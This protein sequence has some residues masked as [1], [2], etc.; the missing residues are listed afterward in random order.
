MTTEPRGRFPWIDQ[1]IGWDPPIAFLRFVVALI[2]T[3]GVVCIALLLA[4]V[5]EQRA[6]VV[7]VSTL[8]AMAAAV[9]EL[10][11]R[12]RRSA[13]VWTMAAGAWCHATL[14]SWFGG[15][16]ESTS[17]IIY[18]LIIALVGWL[19]GMRG[20]IVATALSSTATCGMVVAA[21]LGWLPPAWPTPPLVRWIVELG[22]FVLT[23]A[24]VRSIVGSFRRRLDDVQVLSADLHRAQAVAHVGSWT[25]DLAGDVMQLS[26]ETSRIFGLPEGV[27]GTR[28]S[29]LGRVVTEDRA[30][31]AEAWDAAVAA[32][33]AFDHEHRIRV[34]PDV[35]WVRQIAEFER[36]PDG[37]AFRAVGTTQEVTDRRRTEE[38]LA[39][40]RISIERAS[41]ALFWIAPDG[42]LL[43]ANAAACTSL[44][45]TR[46]ELLARTVADVDADLTD[47]RWAAHRERVARGGA[48]TFESHHR[49]RDGRVF[50]VEIVAS[51]VHVGSEVRECAF[52]RDISER[53]AREAEVIEARARLE[54]TFAALPDLLF[55]MDLEGR[56][57][58]CHA[59][60]GDRFAASVADL[61]GRHVSSVMPPA[62]ASACMAAL[63]EAHETGQSH[64][65]QFEL[66]LPGGTR[67]F[68][69]SVARKPTAEGEVPRF[70]VVSRDVTVRHEAEDALRAGE[71]ELRCILASTADG[72][73]AVN[74]HGRVIRANE[75]FAE[76]WRIPP[77]LLSAGNDE[78]LLAFVL[79]QLNDP[80]GFLHK[81]H[82]LYESDVIETDTLTFKDGRIFERTTA[83]FVIGGRHAG[84]V[85][86]FRDV[87]ERTRAQQRLAIALDVARMVF[88][89]LDLRT[90]LLSFDPS[91]MSVLGLSRLTSPMPLTE[92]MNR[93]HPDDR[94]RFEERA[95]SALQGASP[96]FDC[97]YRMIEAGGERWLH[98]RA[99][100]VE[101]DADGRA[102]LAVGSSLDLTSRRQADEALRVSEARS[103]ELASL[104]RGMCDNVPDMIWAKDLDQRYLFAN[105]AMCDGL[106]VAS[107]TDE[108]VGRTDVFFAERQR[109]LRPE[110]RDWHTFGELCQDTDRVTL[111]RMAPSEFEE[112]GTIKGQPLVLEVHKA[113][114]H[115]VDGRLIG[116]VGSARDITERRR[117]EEVRFQSRKLEAL[118]TLA[119]G[120]AHDFNNILAAI[121]GNADLVAEYLGPEHVAAPSLLEIRKA[122]TRASD[123]VRRI[124]VFGQPDDGGREPV[125]L[126]SLA[127]EVLRLLRSTLPARIMLRTEF[128]SG[129][130]RALAD[131]SQVHEVMVNLSTNAA[132]AIGAQP[133]SIT[134]RLDAVTLDE[135][136]AAA[137]P[138]LEPGRY[139]RLRVTDTGCGMDEEM[140]ERIFDAFYTTK[141]VG[142]GTGLGLSVVHGIMKSHGGAVSAESTPGVGSTFSLFFREAPASSAREVASPPPAT[143]PATARR[144]L[145]VDDEE[146]IVSIATR[147]LA[148]Q[149]H[150]VL[151]FTEPA[152]ALAAF[153][154]APAS[155][156]VIVTDLSMPQMSGIDFARRVLAIDAAV[157]IILT[158]G[159]LLPEQERD[160]LDAGVR[161]VAVKPLAMS[162]LGA[163]IGR[164]P[165]RG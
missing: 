101:R 151:G 100:V 95:A 108:P 154:Q 74:R 133:G 28:A 158:T 91:R 97:E 46:E 64:G 79:D 23:A 39:L 71:E 53:K 140:L 131:A 96:G 8:V 35:R 9:W 104:L 57:L 144:V 27:G 150:E 80:E 86:S 51:E 25:Y 105:K 112:S 2:L 111:E 61:V 142:E 40:S 37:T 127:E 165:R 21:W 43:D 102:L 92:W 1:S 72:I 90:G 163:A 99:A 157:A 148:R 26:A 66:P 17:I 48:V 6:R 114:F 94:A 11:R 89:E 67:W 54:A 65:R 123:L 70:T 34:G 124:M 63:R 45:Y 137:V 138:G 152:T 125:D 19:V 77:S 118:G 107:D 98:T 76:L 116:T 121:R 30:A 52:V 55:E 153:A 47:E 68:E 132:Y 85:W 31:V 88:W 145:Y 87:T 5:P 160:A 73:L 117:F 7:V 146:A 113:P 162:E 75:R 110:V 60:S 3:V 18:P 32:R 4:F 143:T 33:A 20:A 109:A 159:W 56:Y 58:L 128:E 62:S 10:L 106:L 15:G 119:G 155:F 14:S 156:D 24:I 22:A 81:V 147:T 49:T 129:A 115:D 44:G 84:R 41:E 149:G 141:P 161:E 164:Y 59:P 82:L 36:H 120:I 134:Y 93:V 136:Q 122:S 16:V 13:A 139:A 38:A 12:G 83:P 69:L 130:P 126:A 103:R 78:A 42:R 50:P 135:R 29:Y